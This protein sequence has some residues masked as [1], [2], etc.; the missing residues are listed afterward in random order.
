[1]KAVPSSARKI[2]SRRQTM[3][4]DEPDAAARIRLAVDVWNATVAVTAPK[5]RTAKP[6][7]DLKT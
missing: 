7:R 5:G 3:C 2:G 6:C 1:M 4:R